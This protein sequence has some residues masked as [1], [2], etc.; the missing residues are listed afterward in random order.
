[1]HVVYTSLL[2]SVAFAAAEKSNAA[3]PDSTP[4]T[5][6]PVEGQTEEQ[7]TSDGAPA[8]AGVVTPLTDKAKVSG[9]RKALGGDRVYLTTDG[10][11]TAFAKAEALLAKAMGETDGFHG[12]KYF[13]NSP[14]SSPLESADNIVV[15]TLGYRAPGVNGYKAI[16]VTQQPTVDEFLASPEAKDFVAKLIQREAADVAFSAGIRS[17]ETY[18][19]L[20]AAVSAMP[21]T[22]DS[23]IV[24]QRESGG[25]LDTDTFDAMWSPFRTGF[26]KEKSP[27]LYDILPQKGIVLKA[28]RSAAFAKAHPACEAIEKAGMFAKMLS[29]M[30]Q[31]A[32]QFKDKDG[33]PS[34]LDTTALQE[35]LDNRDSLVISYTPE[36]IAKV[37]DLATIQF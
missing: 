18:S 34:P 26:V 5:E 9:I 12:L 27:K 3:G 25:G 35:W 37:D 14:D 21:I 15:M 10:E 28:M 8:T 11:S 17:A 30:I 4:E 2:A 29:A 32:P 31:L 16:V 1:M 33:K 6:T 23:I 20:E 13:A 7:T 24:T 22:V 36:T 19:Q